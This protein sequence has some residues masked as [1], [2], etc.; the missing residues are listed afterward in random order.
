MKGESFPDG[1]DLHDKEPMVAFRRNTNAKG[2]EPWP[3]L[4]F[5]EERALW[6]DSEVFLR[7]STT[8]HARPRMLDWLAELQFS[9]ASPVG[10]QALGLTSDRQ[11]AHFWRHERLALPEAYLRDDKPLFDELRAT[12]DVAEGVGQ[13][14]GSRSGALGTCARIILGK[15]ARPKALSSF[16]SSLGAD[17]IYWSHI[18]LPFRD[19]L[20]RLPDDRDLNADGE[21]TYGA[22]LRDQWFAVLEDAARLTFRS[23]TDA[24]QSS[25]RGLRAVAVAEREFGLQIGELR[26]LYK[27]EEVKV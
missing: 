25:V 15:D 17:R 3:P 18:D 27:G 1:Y 21:V 26:R 7:T 5:K 4:A 6:R 12:I 22:S 16:V 10:L 23:A 8:A 9:P 13:L 19:I 20:E 14:L 24:L 11:D 2:S